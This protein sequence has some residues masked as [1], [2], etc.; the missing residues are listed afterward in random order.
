MGVGWR[1][2]LLLRRGLWFVGEGEGDG[3][4]GGMEWRIWGREVDIALMMMMIQ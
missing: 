4:V 2:L 3:L 1:L